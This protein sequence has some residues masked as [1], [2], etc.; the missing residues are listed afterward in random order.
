MRERRKNIRRVSFLW[1]LKERIDE[2]GEE[3]WTG[4]KGEEEGAEII[5]EWETAASKVKEVENDSLG[6]RS[7]AQ[8][9][10]DRM[11]I[12]VIVKPAAK[13]TCFFGVDSLWIIALFSK[14]GMVR[15][16]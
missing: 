7:E 16:R 6:E 5:P 12:V 10:E 11:G 8:E 4:G 3:E 14:M 9:K 15:I 2:K 1:S 13:G